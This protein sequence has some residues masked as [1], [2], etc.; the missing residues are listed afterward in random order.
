MPFFNLMGFQL[1]KRKGIADFL[2]EVTSRKD[3]AQYWCG[4]LSC[5][6]P[7]LG[8]CPLLCSWH[9]GHLHA[10]MCS[11]KEESDCSATQGK[12]CALS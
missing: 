2:Q 11:E 8:P 4:C 1:P 3:Q 5:S 6:A 12:C 9:G 10:C 7:A